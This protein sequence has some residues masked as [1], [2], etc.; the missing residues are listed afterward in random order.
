MFEAIKLGRRVDK[1]TFSTQQEELR[2]QLLLVQ[3]ELRQTDIPV[4]ILIA[5]VEGAGKG[6]VVNRLYE[7]LDAR[8]LQSFAYWD[9]TDEERQRPR[10][11]RFWRAM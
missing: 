4:I 3:R 2:T 5:G 7:W 1:E 10:Y 11:W 9:E 8:G 6:E